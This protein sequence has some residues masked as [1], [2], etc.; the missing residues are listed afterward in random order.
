MT[1]T[2]NSIPLLEV[3][4][5]SITF[6][7]NKNIVENVSFQIFRG[8]AV[9]LVG[10]SGSGKTITA[11]SILKLL[12]SSALYPSGKI[13]FEDEN[14]FQMPDRRLLDIRG[15]KIGV[16]FQNPF[17]SLNPAYTIGY[18]IKEALL[19]HQVLSPQEI[20]LKSEFLLEKVGLM[21]QARY[22]AAYPHEL[23]GGERQRILIAM[24]IS[25]DPLL[26]IADEPTTSLDVTTQSQILG[27]LKQ[28]QKDMGMA[29]L[30]ISHNL[31]MVQD[32]A[33]RV[34][35]MHQGKI[36]EDQNIEDLF[37]NPRYPYTQSLLESKVYGCPTP[38][39]PE[40]ATILKAQDISVAWCQS[41]LWAKDQ[42]V[43]ELKPT[44]LFV[45]QGE[46]LGIIG[47]T[48]AGKTTLA[49]ALAGLIPYKGEITFL[50]QPASL[51]FKRSSRD[52]NT[53]FRTLW[54]NSFENT[55][56][57]EKL[58]SEEI[59]YFFN[60]NRL[61]LRQN[62]Q[63]IY[64][65]PFSS[66]SPFLTV[67]EIVEEGLLVQNQYAARERKSKVLQVLEQVG[68]GG[69]FRERYP[70]SL[71]GGQCQRVA[72]AR[73]LVLT[74]ALII[75]DEPTS[76]LDEVS[77]FHFLELLHKLQED[78]KLSYIII[79]HDLRIIKAL[80]HRVMVMKN[81]KCIEEGITEKIFE[82]PQHEYT[83]LLLKSY[84]NDG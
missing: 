52:W 24:A 82:S 84:A 38:M 25:N 53:T 23:S 70:H 7:K 81:G 83:Q 58:T 21:P 20:Q 26:L 64:Q 66:L 29:M 54:Q 68:L 51:L 22:L 71:S 80:S 15:G 45:R 60:T 31:K 50:N 9:A 3:Q 8:E 63:F 27:L 17:E 55:L 39:P 76:A 2:S 77:Q 30:F 48:G 59:N 73:A 43:F 10:E 72:L 34:M 40:S 35:V 36:V 32:V 12:P 18:Q 6:E 1:D 4:N 37:G 13:L 5:L 41:S 79:T 62:L 44:S 33:Q 65:D 49:H 56:V 11:L 78:F 14:V 42:V 46:T 28:L 74:P 69:E 47:E 16:V 75:F 67:E 57:P 19:L 61:S